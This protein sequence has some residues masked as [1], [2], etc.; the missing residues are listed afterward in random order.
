MYCIECGS[1][2]PDYGRF[3]CKCGKALYSRNRADNL[4]RCIPPITRHD[5]RCLLPDMGEMGTFLK[6]VSRQRRPFGDSG[7]CISDGKCAEPVSLPIS[8]EADKSQKCIID[9]SINPSSRQNCDFACSS[10]EPPVRDT[11]PIENVSA[12][13]LKR[14]YFVRHWRG[15]LRL[16]I[17]YWINTVLLTLVAIILIR[18]IVGTVQVSQNPRIYA[19]LV[20]SFWV[21]SI[22]ITPWQ[23]V[24]VWKSSNNHIARGGTKLWS[25]ASKAV[26]LLG[27]LAAIPINFG[28]GIPQI[29][30]FWT[31]LT[32][33][34]TAS[35]YQLR[36][37]R[38]A[39]ELEISGHFGFGLASDVKTMLDSHPTITLIHL[40]SDGGRVIEARQLRNLIETRGL[41]TFTAS[42]CS[43]ACVLAF[44]AG[45]QRLIAHN[46]ILG[47]HQYSFPGASQVDFAEQ[48][49][50]DRKW[51]LSKGIPE[52]FID[53]A[54]S[55]S[56][57]MLW[58]P[59]HE[60]LFAANFITAYPNSDQV[61]L[62]GIHLADIEKVDEYLLK[63][64]LFSTLKTYEPDI[65]EKV[66]AEAKSAFMRGESLFELRS[67]VTPLITQVYE[68]RLPNASDA[69]LRLVA[70]L[71]VDQ[72]DVLIESNPENCYQLF[73]HPETINPQMLPQ[74]LRDREFSTMAEVIRSASMEP[75]N[76]P[77][78][79]DVAID[80]TNVL[81]EL[82]GIYGDGL[83]VLD[84]K[85]IS[86]S[87]KAKYCDI[88]LSL[89]RAILRL[90]DRKAAP[91]LRYL[92]SNS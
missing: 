1:Q 72:G 68:R 24:G 56:S 85:S 54:F 86:S 41:S 42:R 8:P 64:P 92:F 57:S 59:T 23:F 91:L 38:D 13:V 88:S 46:A 19:F 87:E 28:K 22:V 33:H 21:I 74:A 34:D 11:D 63:T 62:S 2:N 36:V 48:Y 82:Y 80:L 7:T 40:N 79:D 70:Q 3:C 65:Y 17:S 44:A 71:I 84:K 25:V 4:E 20:I 12:Q 15:D 67:K 26:V 32:G 14:S 18:I 58:K 55:T 27:I 45:K 43:S 52:K 5:H 90:P 39:S 49:A 73:S 37:L 6:D 50:E 78:E 66:T 69:S 89:F 60:E 29:I 31:I 16:G 75:I 10:D 9:G 47:F 76:A 53:R 81:A 83:G 30:E 61:A 77:S 35:Q 51:L